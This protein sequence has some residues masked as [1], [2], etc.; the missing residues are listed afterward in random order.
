V[1]VSSRA[2]SWQELFDKL[3]KYQPKLQEILQARIPCTKGVSA[4]LQMIDAAQLVAPLSSIN[5]DWQPKEDISE[6][7]SDLPFN[8]IIEARKA[9][10][11]FLVQ[12]V[13]E[14]RSRQLDFYQKVV[15]ELGET[16][17]K[18]EVINTLE[19][20]IT[21]AKDTALARSNSA[22]LEAAI[23]EFRGVQLSAYLKS[24]QDIQNEE[25]IGILLPQLSTISPN[26]VRVLST[27]LNLTND[28]MNRSFTAANAEI[29]NLRA[30]GSSDLESSYIA[31]EQSLQEIQNLASEIKGDTYVD[32][33]LY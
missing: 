23:K 1:D 19:K 31:I 33:Q 5:K 30:T 26:P 12:A 27:F 16:F 25:D 7:S 32:R 22:S 17:S 11:T 28:F 21:Q 2:K 14:E 13:Q 8:A 9:V 4:R 6:A 10:D 29:D 18:E 3:K 20:T 24:M 15:R